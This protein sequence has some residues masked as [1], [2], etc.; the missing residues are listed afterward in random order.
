MFDK[1][2]LVGAGGIGSILLEPMVRLLMYHKAG[3][4]NVHVY[5]GDKY[6]E[7]N[8][9]RQLFP[10]EYVGQNK[11]EAQAKKLWSF[12]P[13]II[14]HCEYVDVDVLHRAIMMGDCVRPLVIA[15]VDREM[16]RHVII[17][18]LDQLPDM[19]DYACILPGND[20]AS[21]NCYT[22]WREE[23]K[24]YPMHPFDFCKEWIEP[25][26]QLPG[27]CGDNAVSAPQLIA[28]N[29]KAASL[30]LDALTAILDGKMPRKLF[31]VKCW[32][33]YDQTYE[34][35]PYSEFKDGKLQVPQRAR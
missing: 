7:H 5:D 15:A 4:L 6:E 34:L 32:N 23:G 1:V 18:A 35:Q 29:M 14:P 19:Y 28:A 21:A 24:T 17:T 20:I 16:S 10:L 27:A 30:A 11:A 9:K 26:D 31:G 3:T 12:A 25:S 22:Y 13:N 33:L 8:Q 2:I